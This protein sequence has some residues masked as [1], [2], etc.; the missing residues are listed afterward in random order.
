MR[1]KA[2]IK[3]YERDFERLAEEIGDLRYDSLAEFLQLL[4]RKLELDG[5]KDLKRGRQRLS[6]SLFVA[7][8]HLQQASKASQLAWEISAPYMLPADIIAKVK[9]EFETVADRN[10][11]LWLLLEFNRRDYSNETYR[12]ERCILYDAG[13][14]VRKLKENIEIARLDYRD[15]IFSAEYEDDEQVRDLNF[16]FGSGERYTGGN[17]GPGISDDLPF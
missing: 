5:D 3:N 4:S 14:D 8:D 9:E 1:H 15:V 10:T 16:P 2:W 11:A 17:E 7:K 6:E 12:L 13:G